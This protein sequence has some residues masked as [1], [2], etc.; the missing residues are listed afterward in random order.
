MF[1]RK[2]NSMKKLAI[3]VSKVEKHVA[4][5]SAITLAEVKVGKG[6]LLKL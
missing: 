1:T 2:E 4:V 5:D 3:T 6:K